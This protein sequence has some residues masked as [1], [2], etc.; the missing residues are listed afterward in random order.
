[1]VL[2][3]THDAELVDLLSDL[4]DPWHFTDRV[5][6]EGLSFEYRLQPGKARTRNAIT[7]L[8]LHGAP[9]DLVARA[10]RSA[11]AIE[12]QREP[13]AARIDGD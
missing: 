1:V 8:D 2:A 7:L 5:T 10:L 11:A 13:A 6:D 12:R 9:K 4:Y 3:A